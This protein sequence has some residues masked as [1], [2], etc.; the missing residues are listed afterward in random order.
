MEKISDYF[1]ELTELQLDQFSRL[2]ELY[3]EWNS[4][5]NVLSRKD[6]D[7]LLER[8]VLHS[9]A[10]AK[11]ITFSAGSKVL[12]IGT[13][14]GFPGIPLAIF[15]PETDFLLVDSIGKK[16]KVVEA[17][18]QACS[19]TNVRCMKSRAEDINEKFDFAVTRAVAEFSLLHSW[20]KNKFLKQNI[21][22]L[23]NGIICLKGGDLSEELSGF[24]NKIQTI[25]L[26][27]YFSQ[28]FFTT[29]KIIYYSI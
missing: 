29:K 25:N 27:N 24:E 26:S 5:I 7:S 22:P 4:K 23:P 18:V 19:L 15:F 8:H 16:I 12:D 21:N 20:V 11:F 17:V 9:L 2:P 10:I 13:G 3:R 1:P 28:D 14:G 6:I